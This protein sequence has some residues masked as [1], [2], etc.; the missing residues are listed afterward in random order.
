MRN[1]FN[2]IMT[3]EINKTMVRIDYEDC[4]YFA[5]GTDD[6]FRGVINSTSLDVLYEELIK[7]M[8]IMKKYGERD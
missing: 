3:W 1:K 8:T 7:C 6:G 4:L 5:V 2:T